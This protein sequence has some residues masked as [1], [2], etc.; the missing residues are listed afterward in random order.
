MRIKTILGG[1]LSLL[2]IVVLTWSGLKHGFINSQTLQSVTIVMAFCALI[3][4]VA[5]LLGLNSLRQSQAKMA[6]QLESA[7]S[8]LEGRHETELAQLVLSMGQMETRLEARDISKSQVS[9]DAAPQ[10]PDSRPVPIKAGLRSEAA[11]S[12]V[13]DFEAERFHQVR[14]E[15]DLAVLGETIRGVRSG[16]RLLPVSLQAIMRADDGQVDGYLAHVRLGTRDV[17]LDQTPLTEDVGRE[18]SW[19]AA[20]RCVAILDAHFRT[21]QNVRIMCPL[22]ASF[23]A[24]EQSVGAFIDLFDQSPDLKNQLVVVLGE[25]S[26]S[27]TILVREGIQRINHAGILIGVRCGQSGPAAWLAR[28]ASWIVQGCRRLS[29][30]RKRCLRAIH[31][32]Q[33]AA[34]HTCP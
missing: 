33:K 21:E 5:A 29:R 14:I 22:H 1:F 8:A 27:D 6:A 15:R 4:S 30:R 17:M 26:V 31:A 16:Q 2:T 28:M 3:V 11:K 23:F 32:R 9:D 34:V 25:S 19:M 13:P 7:V 20:E 12:F 10:D 24:N 18:I